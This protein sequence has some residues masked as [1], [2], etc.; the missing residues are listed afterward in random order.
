MSE[1][2]RA[3]AGRLGRVSTLSQLHTVNLTGRRGASGPRP[4]IVTSQLD[5]IVTP[6]VKAPGGNV[7]RV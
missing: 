3:V 6:E 4:W 5:N 1:S 2:N 7:G